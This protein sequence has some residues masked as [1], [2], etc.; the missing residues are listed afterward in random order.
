LP[1]TWATTLT[2]VT[3]ISSMKARP[4]IGRG[5]SSSVDDPVLTAGIA[6]TTTAK[7]TAGKAC[8]TGAV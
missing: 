2:T 3:S 4:P 5:P 1:V 6:I 7:K 8:F